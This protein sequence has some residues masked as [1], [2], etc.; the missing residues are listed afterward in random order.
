MSEPVD[1]HIEIVRAHSSDVRRLAPMFDAY[2]R[3]YGKASDLDAATAFLGARLGQSETVI[4]LAR[5][6]CGTGARQAGGFVQMF[7]SFS[8]VSLCRS[9]ILN[10]LFVC[11]AFRRRGIGRLLLDRAMQHCTDTGARQL[12][13]QTDVDNA[14]AQRLYESVAM[15]RH[16]ILEYTKV[17]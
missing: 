2:R 3:F 1:D 6:E 10:D 14:S 5:V 4:Y 7:P 17:L 9:W 15:T 12:W 11:D 16:D 13:L 8:S